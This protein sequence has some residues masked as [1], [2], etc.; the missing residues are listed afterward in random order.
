M[1][2]GINVRAFFYFFVF[3]GGDLVIG[4]EFLIVV[5]VID[6]NRHLAAGH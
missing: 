6:T 5:G 2:W 3:F 1:V 4:L